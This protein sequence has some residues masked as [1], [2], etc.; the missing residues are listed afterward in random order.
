MKKLILILGFLFAANASAG[1]IVNAAFEFG[2]NGS[3]NYTGTLTGEDLDNDGFLRFTELTSFTETAGGHTLGTLVD[4]G[5]I[6]IA[7]ELWIPNGISWVSFIDTAFMTFDVRSFSCATD[8]GCDARLTSFNLSNNNVP[9]PMS[10]LLL[11][12]GLVWIG[13]LRKKKVV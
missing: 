7:N 1:L 2:L 12:L 10:I 11:G 4:I 6:D 13:L 9:E 3:Y 5:D 8:N